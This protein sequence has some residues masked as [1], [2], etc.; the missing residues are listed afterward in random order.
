MGVPLGRQIVQHSMRQ[1]IGRRPAVNDNNGTGVSLDVA[2]QDQLTQQRTGQ[3][4]A[5]RAG[6]ESGLARHVI[7]GQQ[8]EVI[9]KERCHSDLTCILA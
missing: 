7:M 1:G 5:S 4:Q 8:E 6:R 2:E 3:P 9:C